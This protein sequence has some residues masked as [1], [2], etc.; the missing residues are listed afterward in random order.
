M[1]PLAR[2]P[3]SE[4]VSKAPPSDS[5]SD[6]P[7]DKDA[8]ERTVDL[9]ALRSEQE[10]EEERKRRDRERKRV[11]RSKDADKPSAGPSAGPSGASK[12]SALDKVKVPEPVAIAIRTLLASIFKDKIDEADAKAAQG[13]A[14][15][16]LDWW[17]DQRL[18]L[19]VDDK[20]MPE[21]ALGTVTV[22]AG[23]THF[24]F[25]RAQEAE[26]KKHPPMKQ[27]EPLDP[28]TGEPIPPPPAHP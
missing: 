25:K 26:A 24:R 13:N 21:V 5:P 20:W 27:K 16:V 6:S 18:P 3:P 12:A 23:I 8:S 4:D 7:S 1:K 10:K 28:T 22:G 19:F 2:V 15:T 17:V 9:S 14:L 11:E